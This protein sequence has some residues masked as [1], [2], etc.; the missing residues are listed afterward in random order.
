M[1]YNLQKMFRDYQLNFSGK[2]VEIE[3]NYKKIECFK[4]KIEDN[5][6][7]HLLGLHYCVNGKGATQICQLISKE[8]LLYEDIKKKRE[9]KFY[10][11][12]ERISCYGYLSK[13]LKEANGR[14]L[15]PVENL[16]PNPMK[17]TIVFSEKKGKGEV[18]LGIR[19]D[20]KE[21]VYH[22]TTLHYSRKQKFTNMRSGEVLSVKWY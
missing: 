12:K 3:T 19:K 21:N 7:P 15:Y 11:I 4:I 17:L 10:N 6:F 16:K 20:E 8:L 13:F 22:L 2:I 9:F 14:V 18:V 5:N 1:T